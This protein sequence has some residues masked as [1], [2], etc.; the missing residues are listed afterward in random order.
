M[1]S[2]GLPT[3]QQFTQS[4]QLE[5]RRSDDHPGQFRQPLCLLYQSGMQQNQEFPSEHLSVAGNGWP[6][7]RGS[8][9]VSHNTMQH[10]P[11]M[12]A[13]EAFENSP[14]NKLARFQFTMRPAASHAQPAAQYS[15]AASS[16]R[17]RL[18]DTIDPA[19]IPLPDSKD[20][21]LRHGPTMAEATGHV[22]SKKVAGSRHKGKQRAVSPEAPKSKQKKTAGT[23]RKQAANSDSDDEPKAKRGR[24][25]GAGNYSVPDVDA[26][27][28]LVE[29]ELPLGQRGWQRIHIRF[30]KWARKHRRPERALKSLETKYKQLVRTTKPTGNGVCPPAVERAHQIEDKISTRACQDCVEDS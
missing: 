17:V 2:I 25:Q 12:P 13:S 19:L 16:S 10:G 3:F 29:T 11:Q 1:E 15:A 26:L 24:P 6:Q 9:F 18:E 21:D 27:L 22:A 28:D 5:D 7:G 4:A 8:G 20:A 23:K 30:K 14:P